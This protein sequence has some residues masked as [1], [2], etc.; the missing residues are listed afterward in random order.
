MILLELS[1]ET[2]L[3]N[4]KNC[5]E[6]RSIFLKYFN[7]YLSC[8]PFVGGG[9]WTSVWL[10]LLFK[11]FFTFF[12]VLFSLFWRVGFPPV[13]GFWLVAVM[14]SD[15]KVHKELVNFFRLCGGRLTQLMH[16]VPPLLKQ[17]RS[18]SNSTIS[19]CQIRTLEWGSSEDSGPTLGSC[20]ALGPY[21]RNGPWSLS[22][23]TS[24]LG[25][26]SIS[27]QIDMNYK[28][29]EILSTSQNISLCCLLSVMS[30]WVLWFPNRIM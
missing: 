3:P 25:H 16:K 28:Y 12:L 6:N 9:L 29:S 19:W 17:N 14:L 26:F 13:H 22:Y 7:D 8:L 27:F 30:V 5:I 11:L 24:L 23:T 21:S 10:L 18:C 4:I 2:C 15:L 1:F 20:L